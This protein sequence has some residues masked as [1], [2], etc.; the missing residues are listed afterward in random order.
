MGAL[1]WVVLL[2]PSLGMAGVLA[3][4]LLWPVLALAVRLRLPPPRKLLTGVRIERLALAAPG[5]TKLL[6]VARP[7]ER[8]TVPTF[9]DG[10][11]CLATM[12]LVGDP[13]FVIVAEHVVAC[14]FLLMVDGVAT[15]VEGPLR[16]VTAREH[17]SRF[18]VPRALERLGS[19]GSRPP[20]DAGPR[21]PS[22]TATASRSWA[23]LP[24]RWS[25]RC[26][27]REPK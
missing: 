25:S 8:G 14:P 26:S 6:G 7:F 5:A 18:D 12:L 17:E 3:S 11:A 9:G 23:D 21:S 20:V 10:S 13:P 16:L 4:F 2:V 1:F 15:L 27:V 24:R 19:R 22:A